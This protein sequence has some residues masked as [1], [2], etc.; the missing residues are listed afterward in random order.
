MKKNFLALF[1]A[2]KLL[3]SVAALT[4]FLVGCGSNSKQTNSNGETYSVTAVSGLEIFSVENDASFILDWEEPED[5]SF[6]GVEIKATPR[7][8]NV[9]SVIVTVAKGFDVPNGG[10]GRYTLR[11]LWENMPY[12]VAIRAKSNTGK[13]SIA[14][15]VEEKTNEDS[16]A[17]ESEMKDVEVEKTE[18]GIIVRWNTESLAGT[19]I[20]KVEIITEHSKGEVA[21]MDIVDAKLGSVLLA[22][23]DATRS[24]TL[25]MLLEDVNGNRQDKSEAKTMT[26]VPGEL[27]P[28]PLP[29][30]GLVITAEGMDAT[31]ADESL[32]IHWDDPNESVGEAKEV[33]IVVKNSRTGKIVVD[34][35]VPST[36]GTSYED[37]G[38]GVFI[39]KTGMLITR[40]YGVDSYEV[41]GR[42][43]E[44]ERY[45]N[46]VTGTGVTTDKTNT[47]IL[48]VSL[49]ALS[50]TTV[51]VEWDSDSLLPDSETVSLALLEDEI[52]TAEALMSENEILQDA[53]RFV[54]LKAET[55]YT[56]KAQVI[57]RA[58]NAGGYSL[59]DP[60]DPE[61]YPTIT[62]LSSNAHDDVPGT[63]SDLRANTVFFDSESKAVIR[64]T[65]TAPSDN[66]LKEYHLLITKEPTEKV[67]ET[68]IPGKEPF[69][70]VEEGL[71]RGVMH[72]IQ[73]T[74]VDWADQEGSPVEIFFAPQVKTEA[75]DP[76]ELLVNGKPEMASNGEFA[77]LAVFRDAPGEASYEL[78]MLEDEEVVVTKRITGD[79]T[80]LRF[81]EEE[82]LEPGISYHFKL[83][84]II[85]LAIGDYSESALIADVLAEKG[86]IS[87]GTLIYDP[88]LFYARRGDAVSISNPSVT[89]VLPE[90]ATE[91]SYTIVSGD[92][93]PSIEE[94]GLAIASTGRIEG[95]IK[96]G[97][98][99]GTYSYTVKA[100]LGISNV[101]YTGSISASLRIVVRS[102]FNALQEVVERGSIPSDLS[103]YDEI[104][105]TVLEPY[106]AEATVLAR[107]VS[108]EGDGNGDSWSS[109]GDLE[110]VLNAISDAAENRIYLLLMAGGTYTPVATLEMK[111][112]VAIVGGWT[113]SMDDDW[114]REI[115]SEVAGGNSIRVIF[116]NSDID[117]TALL[118]G[119][120]IRNGSAI[121]GGGMYN[122][123]ASPRLVN[124]SFIDN[125]ASDGAGMYNS[126]S[127]S[128]YLKNVSFS[129]NEAIGNGGG[130]YNSSL[131]LPLLV[132]VSFSGNTA[133]NGGGIYTLNSS[134]LLVNAS[135]SSNVATNSGGGIY[136]NY[137]GA[138]NL[139]IVNSLF[140]GNKDSSGTTEGQQIYMNNDGSETR[141]LSIYNSIVQHGIGKDILSDT[142]DGIGVEFS[143]GGA[144]DI[145]FGIIIERDPELETLQDNGGPVST[146]ALS[147]TSVAIDA[148]L[149]VQKEENSYYYSRDMS[150]WYSD[151]ALSSA[152]TLP[153]DAENLTANDARSIAREDRPDI[154]AYE[155]GSGISNLLR[156]YFV[157][158]APIEKTYGDEPFFLTAVAE[159]TGAITDRDINYSFE[160]VDS[161][162]TVISVRSSGA[163]ATLS[164]EKAGS[165]ELRTIA[166]T[167]NDSVETTIRI[168]IAKKALGDVNLEYHALSVQVGVAVTNAGPGTAVPT[169]AEAVYSISP[170]AMPDGLEFITSTGSFMGTPTSV[171]DTAYE[172]TV[173][174]LAN[175]DSEYYT[176]SV[177]ASVSIRIA[178]GV[179]SQ[180]E[181]LDA[182]GGTAISFLSKEY[183]EGSFQ[184]YAEASTAAGAAVQGLSYEYSVAEG[185]SLEVLGN[186]ASIV[187]TGIS[188]IKVTAHGSDYEDKTETL[189]VSVKK[190]I[191]RWGTFFYSPA[192][193]FI[194]T[195][196]DITA[197]NGVPTP[198]ITPEELSSVVSYVISP[199]SGAPTVE[200]PGLTFAN[201]GEITGIVNEGADTGNYSYTI[202]ASVPSSDEHYKGSIET[203]L[204][205]TLTDVPGLAQIAKNGELP[206]DLSLYDGLAQ[207]VLEPYGS[208]TEIV[209]RYVTP[210]GSASGNSW[211]RA[212][213]LASVLSAITDATASKVY[214]LFMGSGVYRPAATLSMKNYVAIVGG[215]TGNTNVVAQG[216]EVGR[217]V[218]DGAT[219]MQVFSNSNIDSAALLYGV[220]ISNGESTVDGGGMYN[221]FSSPRLINVNFVDNTSS[222][223]GGGM[224]NKRSH[225]RLVNV[226][227]SGNEAK[228]G[229]GMLNDASSPYLENVSFLDNTASAVGGG[230]MLNSTGSSPILV[231]VI[232][233][234][235][236]TG[237]IASGG[238]MYNFVSS[239]ILVNVS[240]LS[241]TA[242]YHGGGGMYNN[243]SSPKLVNVNFVE[244]TAWKGGG[245]LNDNDDKIPYIVNSLFWGNKN[246]SGTTVGEQI[247]IGQA[248]T[249]SIYNSIVQHNISE[250]YMHD[251]R[252]GIMVEAPDEE[253]VNIYFSNIFDVDPKLEALQN[254]GGL[255]Q[256]MALPANSSAIDAGLYV[257]GKEDNYYYSEDRSTWYS[258]PELK[259]EVKLPQDTE[260]LTSS[261]A[262]GIDRVNRPDIGVYEYNKANP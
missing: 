115:K 235:N 138:D 134:A 248:E 61:S 8:A 52:V 30:T 111:N 232:F 247:Y 222:A 151:P 78:Q 28:K 46:A 6:D 158:D 100:S 236:K 133:A 231:N 11:G 16:T 174:A 211:E 187:G 139:R 155:A 159:A 250:D 87:E 251:T 57:D 98:A 168:N 41:S 212:G 40:L 58:E 258:D 124:V 161:L 237:A 129:G 137:I 4:L 24:Y 166:T 42:V 224:F 256:T 9:E 132:N 96:A 55:E 101:H 218:I 238:G 89:I 217:S 15:E 73:V 136:N 60:S 27:G 259:E 51:L 228:N 149:Y 194:Q 93:T 243:Y 43:H 92:E 17:P 13:Y 165:A 169:E 240:F 86:D 167:G 112:Y 119:L 153:T 83:T 244:N 38:N 206:S 54:N 140:W 97:A 148:G 147:V 192:G 77:L 144:V 241:N 152:T 1:L 205:V 154:G 260:D 76:A 157:E 37:V 191:A 29:L 104:T 14:E 81:G 125:R 160:V 193:V 10:V 209:A 143:S 210:E 39:K 5:T 3:L 196:D 21:R 103:N 117:E 71:D 33:E 65:W 59:I 25:Y 121:T 126:P 12:I 70:R 249:L 175:D 195:G 171:S 239:P 229:G 186:E 127:S 44:N 107:F 106:A 47:A 68:T 66:D 189:T 234:N 208:G 128:P 203:T 105:Q 183:S 173:T 109:A 19:D 219:A 26:I 221:D 252:D 64:I 31:P 233:L 164:I 142:G 80:E 262:R 32:L 261:D 253:A 94:L 23:L 204:F 198:V 185:S 230:G 18:A 50:D 200:M 215:W 20:E 35:L 130:M 181:F 201:T 34:M 184:L 162:S 207:T 88:S 108:P 75:P 202:T 110:S 245:M 56:L 145:D 150:D 120:S 63:V 99:L 135:F 190:D 216:L 223:D 116:S 102:N 85:D 176:G 82:G 84:K 53:Y 48:T 213:N 7:D 172:Y 179:F 226:S 113:G 178:K 254:N 67:V 220:D 257:R 246:R 49:T 197:A 170:A 69:Y 45:S 180:V 199:D 62:T 182:S 123:S 214:L 227:F 22:N 72:R 74:A 91:L 131:S 95:T 163:T 188:K 90:L 141:T 122:F 118:Y 2:G 146:M 177:S 79:A 156:V 255:V 242:G 114:T 225:P 36:T